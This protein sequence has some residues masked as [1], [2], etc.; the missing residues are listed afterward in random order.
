MEEICEKYAE[1]MRDMRS[2]GKY[3]E[4]VQIC[5]KYAVKIL[6]SRKICIICGKYAGCALLRGD[7]RD[8]Q[9]I[10]G[11][12]R[13][14][15][16]RIFPTPGVVH[17]AACWDWEWAG[18]CCKRAGRGVM[19]IQRAARKQPSH[20]PDPGWQPRKAKVLHALVAGGGNMRSLGPRNMP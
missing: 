20:I 10:C 1:N 17:T 8:M 15:A 7:M 9:E 6:K 2:S 14:Y 18:R 3:A 4:N 16:E 13:D 5:T 19:Q 12:C 11:I